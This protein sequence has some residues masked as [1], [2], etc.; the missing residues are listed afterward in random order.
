MVQLVRAEKVSNKFS[1]VASSLALNMDFSVNE[2][3]SQNSNYKYFN[4]T[5]LAEQI[6][7][8]KV[9]DMQSKFLHSSNS[10]AS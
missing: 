5:S 6:F 3:C 9:P 8:F 10:N 7:F 2:H 1:R 4:R